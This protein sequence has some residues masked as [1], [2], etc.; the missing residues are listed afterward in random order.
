M[1]IAAVAPD[2]AVGRAPTTLLTS[3]SGPLPPAT[4]L[5]VML[6]LFAC[7]VPCESVSAGA[8]R[9]TC[10]HER[11][12]LDAT[13]WSAQDIV[14]FSALFEDR[15]IRDATILLWTREHR[16]Q[17]SEADRAAV[18]GILASGQREMCE[19]RLATAHLNR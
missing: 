19:R 12:S 9:D 2:E 1:W 14:T 5:P 8:S 13:R 3:A 6:F 11:V 7:S 18:C 16:G 4:V 17:V 10:L 15:M